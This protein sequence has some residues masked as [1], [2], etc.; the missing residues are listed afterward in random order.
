M[1]V[2]TRHQII[3]TAQSQQADAGTI[4]NAELIIGDD[5]VAVSLFDGEDELPFDSAPKPKI[6]VATPTTTLKATLWRRE[7]KTIYTQKARMRSCNNL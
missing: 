6:S 5:P 3:K 1:G 4:H 2:S 7:R